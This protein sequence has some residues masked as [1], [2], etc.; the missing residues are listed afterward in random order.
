[1]RLYSSK[2]KKL[3]FYNKITLVGKYMNEAISATAGV[4]DKISS[5]LVSGIKKIPYVKKI[6]ATPQRE[7]I[8]KKIIHIAIELFKAAA[9]IAAGAAFGALT[10]I[11]FGGPVPII[12]GAVAGGLA[13]GIAFFGTK[14]VMLAIAKLHYPANHFR[15][16]KA[17]SIDSWLNDN[18]EQAFSKTLKS[19]SGEQWY[20]DWLTVKGSKKTNFL[21]FGFGSKRFFWRRFQKGL[22]YGESHAL[23]ELIKKAPNADAGN[24]LKAVND[25]AVFK[26]QIQEIVRA[27]LASIL[28]KNKHS[29]IK[30]IKRKVLNAHLKKLSKKARKIPGS[31]RY[32]AIHFDKSQL[33]DYTKFKNQFDG[34]IAMHKGKKKHYAGIIRLEGKTK[35]HTIFF[36]YKKGQY[37]FYDG[38]NPQYTGFY[39][40]P[41]RKEFKR[42]LHS[43][44][45]SYVKRPGITFRTY[46]QASFQLYGF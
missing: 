34:Y 11:G 36:Q 29:K 46:D 42:G 45:R 1:M 20:Q 38:Y 4:N 9:I 16:E 27:D 44:L 33:V 8:T 40:F 32:K 14:A 15:T 43:H 28:K 10:A 31:T 19:L 26:K 21:C 3:L 24:L 13:A 23:L 2:S 25:K 37:R 12:I 41:N 17:L 18:H 7:K 35:A 30:G 22:C 39:V 6:A 5:F